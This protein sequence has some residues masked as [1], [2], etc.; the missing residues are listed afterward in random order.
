[1]KLQKILK[2]RNL[3]DLLSKEEMM[4]ILLD[5]EYGYVPDT[6]YGVY[7]SEP[8][9]LHSG[10]LC[11]TVQYSTVNLTVTTPYGVHTFPIHRI[12][13]TDG[14][15]RP[16]FAFINFY[17]QMQ[18]F[19]FPVEEV[20]EGDF[21]VLYVKYDDITTDDRDF[22]NGIAGVLL[23]KGQETDTTCG[24]IRLWAWALSRVLDY[25]ETIPTLDMDNA[26]VIG[27]SRLGKTALVAGMTDSRFKYVMSN[28]SGCS[29]AALTRGS[30]GVTGEIGPF[31]ESSETI[32]RIVSFF[33][34][35]FCK[36]YQEYA[37]TNIPDI[38]DQHFL[39]A[40]IAP[41]FAYVGSATM[42]DWADPVSEFLTCVAATPAYEKMGLKGLVCN[43]E[44]PAGGEFFHEGR[45]GY[46]K[47][48]GAHMI[49][50]HDW[51]RYMDY[52]KL[53]KDEKVDN[54]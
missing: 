9:V 37:K 7:Y 4:K 11:R 52:I 53:H 5:N 18:E 30:M 17:T 31:G 25:A 45:I 50:R 22:T 26:A 41:R 36:K 10:L 3:P 19:I 23:P 27:H 35:W 12:L 8:N 28:D 39:V 29:G 13:H 14:K 54:K 24:K 42:D 21:D 1:M 51:K 20:M 16:F 2:E 33:P 38:F 15:K 48:N 43:D 47:T 46:H 32:R 40:S 49:S 34:H 44:I 6:P